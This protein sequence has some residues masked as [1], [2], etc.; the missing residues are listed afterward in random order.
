MLNR[1]IIVVL[2]LSLA[3]CAGGVWKP[4]WRHDTV[5]V[6]WIRIAESRIPEFCH[7]ATRGCALQKSDSTCTVYAPEPIDDLDERSFYVLGEEIA[8]CFYGDFH[9]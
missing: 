6:T 7:D 4:D 2:T 3:A 1:L 9:Q 5:T 8:H